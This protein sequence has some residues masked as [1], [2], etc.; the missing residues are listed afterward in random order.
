MVDLTITRVV[1]AHGSSENSRPLDL[2]VLSEVR[3]VLDL[4]VVGHISCGPINWRP[5][6]ESVFIA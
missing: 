2:P 5:K 1:M 3:K 4:P 6:F